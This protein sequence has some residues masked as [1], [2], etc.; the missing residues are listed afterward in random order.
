[1]VGCNHKAETSPKIIKEVLNYNNYYH[2]RAMKDALKNEQLVIDK[3][4]KMMDKQGHKQVKV[5]KCV[6]ILKRKKEFW[7][8]LQMVW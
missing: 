7:V 2:S 5:E 1:M 3:Y 6:F 8:P 4:T